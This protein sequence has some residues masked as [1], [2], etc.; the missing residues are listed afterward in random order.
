MEAEL[1]ADPSTTR[2]AT[3]AAPLSTAGAWSTVRRAWAP[4]GAAPG[5]IVRWAGR[6]LVSCADQAVASAASFGANILL[7][8]WLPPV[9]YGAFAVAF[10]LFLFASAIHNALLVD[11]ACV[12]GPA[13]FGADLPGYFKRLLCLHAVWSVAASLVIAAVGLAMSDAALRRA[14][15]GLA[16]SLPFL[17]LLWLL[18]RLCYV[19]G[20]PISA[21]VSSAA[22]APVLIGGLF[23]LRRLAWP[24]PFAA[25]LAMAVA[26]AAASASAWRKLGLHAGWGASGPPSAWNW[27]ARTGG[28]ANG[29]ARPPC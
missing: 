26:A 25:L 15:Y 10:A 11:P 7:A 6:G 1:S 20:E 2:Q 4:A 3:F 19:D 14:F 27:P 21:L 28:M 29:S 23:L 9:D 16:V 17:L 24:T 22:Y 18:R 13:R 5:S 8:R 12:L